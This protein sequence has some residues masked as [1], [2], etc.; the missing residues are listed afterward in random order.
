LDADVATREKVIAANASWLYEQEE[1]LTAGARWNPDRPDG[2]DL[3]IRANGL[4]LGRLQPLSNE[5]LASSGRLDLD[6]AV[7]GTLQQPRAV[8]SLDVSDGELQLAMLGERFRD[9]QSEIVFS[10]QRVDVRRLEIGSQSGNARLSGWIEVDDLSSFRTDLALVSDNFTAINSPAISADVTS[11]ITI[12]GSDQDLDVRGTIAVPRARV[13][14]EALPASGAASVEPW[15]LTIEGVYGAGKEAALAQVE[16]QA[17]GTPQEAPNLDFLR[18]NL[19]LDIPRNA[20]VQGAGTS[21][22]LTGDL[23]VRKRLREPFVLSGTIDTRRGFASVMGR[24]FE[25]ETGTITFRGIKEINPFLDILAV[26]QTRGYTVYVEI[27]G[28]SKKPKLD[29]YSVPELDQADI[30]SLL[31]F[32]RTQDKLSSSEQNGLA[33]SVAGSVAAGMLEQSLGAGLGLDTIAIDLGD[34][35]SGGS[36]G[37]GRYISNDLY[38]SYERSFRDPQKANRGGN[39][40]GLEFDLRPRIKLRGTGSDFGETAVDI[41]WQV[42]Y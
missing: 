12:K 37:V 36:V 39:T 10:G 14:Y 31:L 3:R 19:S 41:F 18:A 23:K 38:L 20:W 8:G 5:I 27:T 40:V 15:Q 1:V 9:L 25:I 2:L 22:E 11:D 16:T 13:R 29:F 42:D 35:T 21:V 26:H 6:L 30:I 24:R 4:D 7:T 34:E 33:G 32:G 28:E 17:K